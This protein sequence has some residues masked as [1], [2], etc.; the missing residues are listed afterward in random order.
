M[1]SSWD[2][3]TDALVEILVRLPPNA[4]RHLRLVCQHWRELI[5]RRTVTDMRRRTKIIAVAEG[6]FTSVIDLLTPGSS[7]LWPTDTETALKYSTMSI[8]G[9]CNG[10][11]CLCDDTAPGGAITVAN[12]S[13]GEAL[14]LPPL[15][16]PGA[17]AHLYNNDNSNRKWHQ[18]YS[19]AYHHGTGSYKVVHVPC[20]FDRF[21][22]PKIVHV[23]TLGD[24]SWRDV[25]T[26]T[27]ARCSLGSLSLVEVDGTVYWLTEDAGKIMAFDLKHECVTRT[28]PVAVPSMSSTCRLMKV[29]GRLAVAVYNDDSAMVWVLEGE[30]W[31]RHYILETH[32]QRQQ[33]M[34]M[35]MMQQEKWS[36]RRDL[37]GPHLVH[38]GYLLTLTCE[39]SC[40]P[41]VL[42]RHAISEERSSQ[43]NVVLI[44]HKDRGEVVSHL[45]ASIYQTFPYIETKESLRVYNAVLT[46]N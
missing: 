12:P 1:D 46:H 33:E 37:A 16:M 2:L 42:Y 31:S 44:R 9:S 14:R 35:M 34:W 24:A 3:P 39:S 28:E 21:W 18:T 36:M 20:H 29:H 17:A 22:Q 26:G 6:G 7:L 43:D 11:V 5:D 4:R 41:L 45:M 25:Y 27:D 40:R 10:L 32:V 23:F 30:S 19:F 8:V 13:T 15:P 38:G